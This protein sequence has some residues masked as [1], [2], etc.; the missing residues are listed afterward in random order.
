MTKLLV[1]NF[2]DK[3]QT[4]STACIHHIVWPLLLFVTYNFVENPLK[5]G[6][7]FFN[8]SIMLLLPQTDETNKAWRAIQ[9]LQIRHVFYL[10]I[11]F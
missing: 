10:H 6:N 5:N 8:Y 11:P 4:G 9:Q 7:K 3:A 2:N 1:K